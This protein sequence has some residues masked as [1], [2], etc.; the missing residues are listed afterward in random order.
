[1]SAAP[2]RARDQQTRNTP[3]GSGPTAGYDMKRVARHTQRHI[4]DTNVLNKA[5]LVNQGLFFS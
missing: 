5:H 3:D 2:V 4:S 1:M